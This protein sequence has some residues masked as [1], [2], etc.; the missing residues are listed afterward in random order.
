ML[1]NVIGQMQKQMVQAMQAAKIPAG[2]LAQ[3]KE[4]DLKAQA[5]YYLGLTKYDYS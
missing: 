3:Q 2:T 1:A 4:E 5:E